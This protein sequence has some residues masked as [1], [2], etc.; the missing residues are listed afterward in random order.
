QEKIFYPLFL[1]FHG[2]MTIQIIFA[3]IQII[4]QGTGP[5]FLVFLL[6]VPEIKISAPACCFFLTL[7]L[8][9]QSYGHNNLLL[10]SPKIC[11]SAGNMIFSFIQ[12]E[13]VQKED[14]DTIVEVS[15]FKVSNISNVVHIIFAF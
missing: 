1:D 4:L 3:I 15:K 10:F 7:I 11:Q 9:W 5:I 8:N 12:D 6:I 2:F 13:A 14:F